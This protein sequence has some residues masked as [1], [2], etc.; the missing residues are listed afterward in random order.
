VPGHWGIPAGHLVPPSAL[1]QSLL[2]GLPR[3]PEGA[4]PG[5][6]VCHG[7]I[8]VLQTAK[9]SSKTLEQES[10]RNLGILYEGHRAGPR[11]C[12]GGESSQV[13]V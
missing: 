13:P 10:G 1:P 6:C 2:P 4:R 9:C 7:Y 3:G 8:L 11:H 5:A 12:K